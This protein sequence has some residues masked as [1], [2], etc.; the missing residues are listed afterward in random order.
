[1]DAYI[2]ISRFAVPPLMVLLTCCSPGLPIPA[3]K[4]E[5]KEELA[6]SKCR[7]GVEAKY[8]AAQRFFLEAPKTD[9]RQCMQTHG[10][11]LVEK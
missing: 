5:H 2:L 9:F 8:N 1:M 4:L 10:Y 11:K 6:W 7:E 3:G